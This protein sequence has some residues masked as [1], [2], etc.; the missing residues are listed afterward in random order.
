M[1][2]NRL[3]A[4]L[5]LVLATACLDFEKQTMTA[6]YYEKTDTMVILQHYEGIFGS[7][8]GRGLS[9]SE[10]EEL[11]GLLN[12]QRTYFFDNWLTVYDP[13]QI[14]EAIVEAKAE[15]AKG[16]AEVDGAIVE[17]QIVLFKLL[18]ANVKSVSGPF[19]LNQDG[20]LSA[21]QQVTIR[22][23]QKILKAA[24]VCLRDSVLAE[25][26]KANKGDLD[27]ASLALLRIA[28][29]RDHDFIQ[30]KGNQLRVRLPMTG[31]GFKKIFHGKDN[32]GGELAKRLVKVVHADEL[33]RL[34]LGQPKAA[35]I[36]MSVSSEE[37]EYL[38]NAVETVRVLK[39]LAKDFDPAKYKRKFFADTD[40]KYSGKR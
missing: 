22:N 33:A 9:G 25:A 5:A 26:N 31:K 38:P 7:S 28:A 14:K 23:V 10:R 35:H 30:L 4:V 29:G 16:D 17:R 12:G 37:K 3:V 21:M 18:L 20:K 39:G 24:N 11:N 19:Y 32:I 34:T 40:K 27:D 15:I 2:T 8:K 1:K 36:E 6:R 13:D